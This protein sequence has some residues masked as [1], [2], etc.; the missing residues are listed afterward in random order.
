MQPHIADGVSIIGCGYVC[1]EF[2]DVEV[3][4]NIAV[5]SVIQRVQ[6]SDADEPATRN[7]RVEYL[8]ESDELGMFSIRRRTGESGQL[9]YVMSQHY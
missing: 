8:L 4:E 9:S 5:G 1:Q 2:Y 6:A 7:S 3:A